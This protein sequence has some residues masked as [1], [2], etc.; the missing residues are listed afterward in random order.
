[1]KFNK[2]KEFQTKKMWNPS[3]TDKTII[4]RTFNRIKMNRNISQRTNKKVL[5]SLL[6]FQIIQMVKFTIIAEG[7]WYLIKDKHSIPMIQ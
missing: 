2:P 3:V 1:M 5:L 6:N 4:L 7:H